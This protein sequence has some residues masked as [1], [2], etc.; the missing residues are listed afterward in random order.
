MSELM[1]GEDEA[2]R[3]AAESRELSLAAAA[4]FAAVELSEAAALYRRA[5]DAMASAVAH[6][7]KARERDF[8]RLLAAAE[9]FKG[10]HFVRAKQLCDRVKPSRIKRELRVVHQQFLRALKPRLAKAYRNT[11]AEA[12]AACERGRDYDGALAILHDHPWALT[13]ADTRRVGFAF[14]TMAGAIPAP[15]GDQAG[16]QDD[17]PADKE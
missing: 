7:P 4:H 11:V 6:A 5:G 13:A 3:L 9:Y 17:A 14:A 8:V 2:A 10:G 12:L 1:T 15:E 16:G